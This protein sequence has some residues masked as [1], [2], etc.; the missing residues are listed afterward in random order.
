MSHLLAHPP[1]SGG[2]AGHPRSRDSEATCGWILG[3]RQAMHRG[4]WG[5]S[6]RV[7]GRVGSTALVPLLPPRDPSSMAC[8]GDSIHV[9]PTFLG[10]TGCEIT[11]QAMAVLPDE[12]MMTWPGGP[13]AQPPAPAAQPRTPPALCY[14]S[15]GLLTSPGSQ[16][17]GPRHLLQGL[18]SPGLST[19]GLPG[20][21][22]LAQQASHH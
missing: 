10:P 9:K 19:S 4:W 15:A 11:A 17:P 6:G 8:S 16:L 1:V 3:C 21:R 18:L 12:K 2:R 7:R 20:A 5:E 13:H 22:A 14:R